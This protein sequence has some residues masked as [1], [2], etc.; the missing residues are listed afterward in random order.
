L[1]SIDEYGVT[2]L[3]S[4]IALMIGVEQK[5]LGKTFNIDSTSLTGYG[6]YQETGIRKEIE[7]DSPCFSVSG[8]NTSSSQGKSDP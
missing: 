3:F 6:E 2:K 4:E 1:D 7:A 5:L 8:S